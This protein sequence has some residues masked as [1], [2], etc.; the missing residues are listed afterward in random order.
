MRNRTEKALLHVLTAALLAASEAKAFD[1]FPEFHSLTEIE[2]SGLDNSAIIDS[3]YQS[4]AITYMRPSPWDAEFHAAP[5]AYDLTFGS[6]NNTHFLHYDRLKL[7]KSL[8]DTLEFRFTYFKERDFD[9]DQTHAILE[10]VKR[11]TPAF[12]VSVYRQPSHFKRENDIGIAL[13]VHLSETHEFRFF[14]TWVDFT[15]PEHNDRTDTF[16]TGNE[17]IVIGFTDRWYSPKDAAP[18]QFVETY[19]RYESPVRRDFK[20]DRYEYKYEKFTVGT[21]SRLHLPR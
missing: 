1:I 21:G 9:T 16:I 17:P 7:R 8:L 3:E 13:L 14:N 15:R 5:M 18:G 6:F 4:D 19:L 2:A 11:L 12:S 20:Y 10:L